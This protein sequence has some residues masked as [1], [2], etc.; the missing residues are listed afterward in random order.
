VAAEELGYNSARVTQHHFGERNGW[1]PAPLPFLATVGQRARRIRLGT[2]VVTMPLEQ[3]V[4]LAEDA[5]V[6][7]LLLDGRLELG[8]GSGLGA[9]IFATF[10]RDFEARREQTQAGIDRLLAALRTEPLGEGGRRLQPPNP[11]LA[12]RLWFAVMSENGARYAASRG[13]GL[14]LGRVEHGGGSPV[15]NQTRT[16][17]LYR[18]SLGAQSGSARIAAGRTV[19]PAADRATALR[20]MALAFEPT[21]AAYKRGGFVPADA[22]LPQV[23]TRLHVLYGHPQEIAEILADE[24]ARIGWTELLVQ[25]DPGALPPAKARL[26]LERVAL[27]IAPYLPALPTRPEPA[28][29]G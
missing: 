16:T 24:Q 11:A 9:E 23:L 26:A 12:D 18:E 27:E 2:V 8:L 13:L 29:V 3:P 17:R 25:V 6:T 19:Y 21:I 7:D 28:Q 10:G 1:L 20:D 22:T 15:A 4:R 14:L 5:A